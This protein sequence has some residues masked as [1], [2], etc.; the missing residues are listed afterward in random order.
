MG[1]ECRQIELAGCDQRSHAGP[2]VGAGQRHAVDIRLLNAG[3]RTNRLRYLGRRNVLAFPAKSVSDSIDEIEK[4]P[5]IFSHQVAGTKP[6]VPG[7]EDASE[8]LL[9]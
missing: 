2:A 1:S 4:A 5:F 9:F 7:F 3:K 8:D 6:G